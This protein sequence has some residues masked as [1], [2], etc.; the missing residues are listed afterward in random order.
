MQGEKGIG[1]MQKIRTRYFR[2]TMRAV[3]ALSAGF[4]L[5]LVA[6]GQKLALE[7]FGGVADAVFAVLLLAVCSFLV[8]TFFP[9]FKG[10][11]RW[12]S[13]PAL[14]TVVFFVGVS[15]LWSVPGAG[16]IG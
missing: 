16:M 15:L 6:F 12:F 13:I 3:L 4:L 5:W 8:F 10:D 11:K 1:I 2:N 9:F 7:S 14:L